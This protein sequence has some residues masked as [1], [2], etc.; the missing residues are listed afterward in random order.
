M[1]MTALFLAVPLAVGLV[2][3]GLRRA[4][5]RRR[6]GLTFAA[7]D[8]G[9]GFAEDGRK[10]YYPDMAFPNRYLLVKSGSDGRHV[11][12]A[13]IG[14]NPVGVCTDSTD[15]E[16]ADSGKPLSVN[17]FGAVRGTQR[18]VAAGSIP[19][20]SLLVPAANGRIQALPSAAGTYYVCG[21]YTGTG[22]ATGGYV[23]FIPFVPVQ[24]V[25]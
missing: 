10:T 5:T 1:K 17:L 21:R 20:W 4:R 14:D 16:I 3:A 13:G 22:A 9:E 15:L 23:E 11:T 24:T 7:N 2:H 19:A 12:L 25:V 18:G 8:L 6:R